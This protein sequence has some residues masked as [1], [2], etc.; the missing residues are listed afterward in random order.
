M[1]KLKQ[2]S[3]TLLPLEMSSNSSVYFLFDRCRVSKCKKT[4]TKRAYMRNSR[5]IGMFIEPD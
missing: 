2:G 5:L 3:L 4:K 1:S